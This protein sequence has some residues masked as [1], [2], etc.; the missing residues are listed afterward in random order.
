MKDK[1]TTSLNTHESPQNDDIL[2]TS[3]MSIRSQF[4]DLLTL[5]KR[6]QLSEDPTKHP[7]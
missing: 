5:E 4:P 6:L 3:L 2:T 7:Q 1:S